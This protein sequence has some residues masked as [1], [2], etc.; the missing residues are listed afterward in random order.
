MQKKILT[1]PQQPAKI[2]TITALFKSNAGIFLREKDIADIPNIL[3]AMALA[4]RADMAH[5][6]KAA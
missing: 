1:N 2:D 5:G 3:A 4:M 6:S